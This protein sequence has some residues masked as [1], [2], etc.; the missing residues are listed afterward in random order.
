MKKIEQEKLAWVKR[1]TYDKRVLLKEKDFQSKGARFQIVKF[2]GWRTIE[3][4]YHKKTIELFYI[5]QGVGQ[6]IINGVISSCK[7]EDF[8]LI[9]RLDRHEIRNLSSKPLI[10][11]IF[12]TNEEDNDIYWN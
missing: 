6:L 10:I 11:H 4:H 7:P 2:A 1:F 8:F 9:E 3:P 12:K 5:K